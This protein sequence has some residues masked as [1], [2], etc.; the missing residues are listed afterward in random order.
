MRRQRCKRGCV[1]LVSWEAP[2]VLMM[3]SFDSTLPDASE[4][5]FPGHDESS[6]RERVEQEVLLV[7]E[8]VDAEIDRDVLGRRVVP[9]HIDHE[10]VVERTEHVRNDVRIV[11]RRIL[12]AAEARRDGISP[13]II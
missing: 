11:E 13:A 9:L 3:Q 10:E 8:I 4:R 1:E 12:L 5:I 2:F 6:S 7:E